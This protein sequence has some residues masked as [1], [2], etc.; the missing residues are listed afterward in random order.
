MKARCIQKCKGV[1]QQTCS[2][3]T[4]SQALQKLELSK[5]FFTKTVEQVRWKPKLHVSPAC[6][7][8]RN[9][10]HDK[11]CGVTLL[12]IIRTTTHSDPNI[13]GVMA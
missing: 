8:A 7:V 3:K 9:S 13:Q 4:K 1:L 11:N 2:V 5:R 10:P 6:S 12:E